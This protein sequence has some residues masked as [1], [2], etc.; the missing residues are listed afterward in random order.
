MTEWKK[1]FRIIWSGQI[2]STLSSTTVGYAVVFWLSIQTKSAEVLAIA[3][4]AAL[5]PQ[6]ICGPFI[7]VLIDRW[8]R[9]AI[10]IAADLFIAGCS[11]ILAILF[12]RGNQHIYLFYLLLALR[13][14]GSAFHIPAMQASVP[15]LAPEAELMRISGVNQVIQSLG[16]IAGPPLAALMISNLSMT[17]VL[18]F[19]VLGAVVATISLLLV[20]IPNPEKKAV[21]VKSLFGDMREGLREVFTRRGLRWLFIMAILVIFFVMPIAALFPLLTINHFKGGTFQIS[22]IEV[23]WGVGMLIGGGFLG[24]KRIQIDRI[25]LINAM[26]V[27]LGL[28]FAFSGVVPSNAYWAFMVLTMVGGMSMSIYS[29]AFMVVL[30]SRIEPSALGRVFSIYGSLTLLPSIV[31]LL[32]TGLIAD[33]IGVPAAF[34]ISG[35]VIVCLGVASYLIPAIREMI[36]EEDQ[37]SSPLNA[38]AGTSE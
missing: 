8:S 13:S 27:L 24:L 15:L 2:L 19:D 5:M 7:G 21:S 28:T 31:G 38:E 29:G 17:H 26:Y 16:I 9:R 35:V 3:T 4:M 18:L 6:L 37:K 14:L 36:G 25:V 34:L 10:M 1:N 22:M 20:R 30:Q 23:C 32:Y 12:L 11:V 33:R